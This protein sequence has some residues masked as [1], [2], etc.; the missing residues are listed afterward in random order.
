M[1][2]EAAGRPR[3]PYVHDHRRFPEP[4]EGACGPEL[5]DRV[6]DFKAIAALD[7]YTIDWSRYRR[8][9]Y[10][11]ERFMSNAARE[12]VFPLL[13]GVGDRGFL[14]WINGLSFHAE[15]NGVLQTD[16][17]PWGMARWKPCTNTWP[18]VE[19]DGQTR[20]THD[21]L[22]TNGSFSYGHRET[23]N[24]VGPRT[25]I[26]VVVINNGA[27][28]MKRVVEK[29]DNDAPKRI[30]LISAWVWGV[31]VPY[32]GA[33]WLH[34]ATRASLAYRRLRAC[35]L[36]VLLIWRVWRRSLV[37]MEEKE[38]ARGDHLPGGA[39]HDAAVTDAVEDM[40]SMLVP[41]EAAEPAPK[42]AR[43]A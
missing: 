32:D 27:I 36:R 7:K 38:I 12:E 1:A 31:E 25:H 18:L 17:D 10:A 11:L 23:L 41:A 22:F 3:H 15:R 6:R 16:Y 2:S 24:V 19:E 28:T 40:G 13:D 5:Y 43:T 9:L 4:L 29:E 39:V 34:A 8:A 37:I 14:S 26:E 35:F 30:T 42:H 20:I 21:K 33:N